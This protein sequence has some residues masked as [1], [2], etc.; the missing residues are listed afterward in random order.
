MFDHA[1]LESL[2]RA[3]PAPPLDQATVVL[4]VLRQ[5]DEKRVEPA[6]IRLDPVEGAV[7]DRW[8]QGASPKLEAQVTLMRA[9]VAGLLSPD[10]GIFGDNVFATLDTSAQNLPPGTVLRLGTARLVVTPKAHTGCY[11][12]AARAGADALAL[13]REPAWVGHQ[14]RGVHLRVLE[15][16]EVGV[17]D[18]VIVEHRPG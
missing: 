9:D 10:P 14:L 4:L 3:L 8:S 15:G 5:P 17:G 12:F 16:G 11:K 2:L 1:T 13:T 6:R 7:G 18:A